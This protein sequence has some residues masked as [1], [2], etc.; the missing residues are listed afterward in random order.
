MYHQKKVLDHQKYLLWFIR[1]EPCSAEDPQTFQI[2]VH[3]FGTVSLPTS[4][5]YALRR[6]A[7][8][9]VRV[10]PQQPATA[11]RVIKNISVDN[12]LDYAETENEAI[13]QCQ[14]V[15]DLTAPWMSLKNISSVFL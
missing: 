6:T 8:G 1:R 7:E 14:E 12:Y 2:T 5:I 4:C 3:I 9:S 10:E 11:E 13:T 15:T